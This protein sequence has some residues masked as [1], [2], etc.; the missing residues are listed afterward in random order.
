MRLLQ[1][2]RKTPQ[3]PHCDLQESI[4]VLCCKLA[5]YPKRSPT[6]SHL[7]TLYLSYFR[8]ATDLTLTAGSLGWLPLHHTG[9]RSSHAV[10]AKI[11][12]IS[13]KCAR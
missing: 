5:S 13:T 12:S 6:Q 11:Q 8:R 10:Q 3:P 2:N 4:A 9:Y 7:T 1:D